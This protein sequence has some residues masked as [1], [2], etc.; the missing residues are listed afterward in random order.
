MHA[1]KHRAAQLSEKM[2]EMEN[3]VIQEAAKILWRRFDLMLSEKVADDRGVR[4]SG[5]IQFGSAIGNT[6]LRGAYLSKCLLSSA[7]AEDESAVD[8]EQYES[9]HKS[10]AN[11][12]YVMMMATL[13]SGKEG[14]L[15][16]R[17]A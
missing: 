10:R 7:A 9:D 4:T 12:R 17:N 3:V 2:I 8:I 5:K 13:M 16:T 14:H 15:L 6:E 1:G 11:Y